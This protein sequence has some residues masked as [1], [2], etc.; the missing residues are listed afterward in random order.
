MKVVVIYGVEHKGSTYHIAQLL[1]NELGRKDNEITEFFLPKDMPKF[2]CGCFNCIMRGDELCPHYDMVKPI[3]DAMIAADLLIFDSPVYVYHITG[4]MK[5]LL[6]HFG[7]C[8]M[9]HRPYPSMFKKAAV[10][11][12][13]AAGAGMKST[14]K[15]ITDSLTFWGVAKI[16]TYGKAVAAANWQGVSEKT[17]SKIEKDIKKLSLKVKNC[18][19]ITRPS[20]KVRLIF[21]G[22]RFA[23]KRFDIGEI[24]R[25]YWTTKG[26]LGKTRPWKN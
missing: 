11:L 15:D 21:Y 24:D 3:K 14:N 23:H 12:S 9:I 22:M 4:Q 2:C 10:V 26:W 6:D 18:Y 1:L 19:P 20:L 16:Y 13:T 8:W 7:Y 17:K 25:D 5:V